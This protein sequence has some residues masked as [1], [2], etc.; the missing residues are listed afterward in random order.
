MNKIVAIFI[1]I[2]FFIFIEFVLILIQRST[3]MSQANKA[4]AMEREIDREH[5]KVLKI[6]AT[7][8]DSYFSAEYAK[9]LSQRLNFFFLKESKTIFFEIENITGLKDD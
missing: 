5:Q 6:Q 9:N 2:L 3:V 8:D 1:L 4:F 7:I